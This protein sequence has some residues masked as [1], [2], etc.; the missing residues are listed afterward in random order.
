MAITGLVVMGF[1]VGAELVS[2]FVS[3]LQEAT[4]VYFTYVSSLRV[5]LMCLVCFLLKVL[6]VSE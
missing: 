1:G 6:R 5:S 3:A 4:Q 2:G